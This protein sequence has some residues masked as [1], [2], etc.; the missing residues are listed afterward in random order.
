MAK[1]VELLAAGMTDVGKVRAMNQDAIGMFPDTQIWLVADGMGGHAHGEVASQAIIDAAADIEWGR[2]ADRIRSFESALQR[3][4]RHLMSRARELGGQVMGSTVVACL[5][6]ENCAELIWAGDSRAYLLRDGVLGQQTE[7]HSY[8]TELIH[9]GLLTE[10]QAENHPR[11]N[12]ITRAVG[13]DSDLN[14]ERKSV[15][16]KHGDRLLLCSDGISKELTAADI[17]AILDD[18]ETPRAACD[19]LY[20]AVYERRARDNLSAIVMDVR[21]A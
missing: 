10:E 19:A 14:L 4:N 1:K 18:A 16:L 6:D 17:E 15:E 8:V 3:V 11:A 9:A 12:V 2:L 20:S 7:D 21:F 13:G 5:V